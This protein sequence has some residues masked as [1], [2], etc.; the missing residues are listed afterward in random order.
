MS[1]GGLDTRTAWY[2][3][4]RFATLGPVKRRKKPVLP[5]EIREYF[6]DQGRE[7][8]KAGGKRRW[9]GVSAAERTAHAKRAVAAR[10]AKKKRS[11]KGKP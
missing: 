7:G 9:E 6:R 3:T 5:T 11:G 10:E 2:P 8:G 1:R 4:G